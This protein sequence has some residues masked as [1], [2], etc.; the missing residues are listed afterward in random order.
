MAKVAKVKS[1][2]REWMRLSLLQCSSVSISL[3]F[4]AEL[5]EED[6]FY[7][8]VCTSSSSISQAYIGGAPYSRHCNDDHHHHHHLQSKLTGFYCSRSNWL[9]QIVTPD[10]KGRRK[11]LWHSCLR[12]WQ[13]ASSSGITLLLG[14]PPYGLLR[15]HNNRITLSFWVKHLALWCIRPQ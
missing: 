1:Q 8:P 11:T 3:R 6:D 5:R 10:Q 7:S 4:P 15:P 14:K 12:P 13:S 2:K 9:M